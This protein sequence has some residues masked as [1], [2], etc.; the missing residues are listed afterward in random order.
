MGVRG[1]AVRGSIISASI[2]RR[3]SSRSLVL[4]F[5]SRESRPLKGSDT[6]GGSLITVGL[7]FS[8]DV[9]DLWSAMRGI[10]SRGRV[11]K[12]FY[13]L[14]KP[15][16]KGTVGKLFRA[17]FNHSHRLIG[18]IIMHEG[19]ATFGSSG[20]ILGRGG[21]CHSWPVCKRIIARPDINGAVLLNIMVYL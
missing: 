20:G 6:N 14:L 9:A 10:T 8:R 15:R 12:V 4:G 5:G 11:V 16:P 1:A 13:G 19:Y 21:S 3:R 2:S 7:R 17:F 18:L